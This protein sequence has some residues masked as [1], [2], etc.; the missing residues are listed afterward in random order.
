MI[1]INITLKPFA[2][3][4]KLCKQYI[5]SQ[6]KD[7]YRDYRKVTNKVRKCTRNISRFEQ[8]EIAKTVKVSKTTLKNFWNYVHSKKK[9]KDR[10]G[11]LEYVTPAGIK[12]TANTD[13]AKTD[14]LNHFFFSK[15]VFQT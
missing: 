15:R 13:E 6:D 7:I 8:C 5:Q 10:I 3:K 4:P 1:V 9:T 2:E 11:D 12:S 14:T